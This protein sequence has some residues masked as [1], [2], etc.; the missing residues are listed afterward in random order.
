MSNAITVGDEHGILTQPDELQANDAVTVIAKLQARQI[1]IQNHADDMIAIYRRMC[2]DE[3]SA[4]KKKIQY[5]QQTLKNFATTKLIEANKAT[6]DIRLPYATLKTRKGSVSTVVHPDILKQ[7]NSTTRK[8]ID[9][10]V[11][12][13]TRS[14]NLT[15]AKAAKVDGVLPENVAKM[16]SIEIGEAS[17]SVSIINPQDALTSP[18]TLKELPKPKEESE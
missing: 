13:I 6:G 15:N 5:H 14:V 7:D 12:K 3:I 10:G 8:L 18:T 17:F 4:L 11:I 1:D 16:V 2:N 9:L